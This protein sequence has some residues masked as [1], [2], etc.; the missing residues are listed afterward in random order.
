MYFEQAVNFILANEGE[1]SDNPNDK[2]GVT[3]FGISSLAYPDIDILNLTKND[4]KNIYRRDFWDPFPY[5][6][7]KNPEIAI[8]F[9]DLSVN[10]G[11]FWAATLIQR[12]LRSAGKNL[13][14]DGI[15]GPQ[16][17]EAINQ[18][19]STDL[20]AALKSEAAGYYR[21]IAALRPKEKIFLKGWLKR[22][23]I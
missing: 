16:T 15:F 7:I 23:Y 14:E 2:G 18:A 8:K 6:D 12:A 4:A 13:M 20:L 9:F 19:D 5:N 22:A 10:I 21:T 17:L 3:K 11:N 1:Y